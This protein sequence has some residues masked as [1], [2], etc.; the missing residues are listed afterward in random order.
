MDLDALDNYNMSPLSLAV[1]EGKEAISSA[2]ISWDCNMHIKDKLGNSLLH[3]A[4]LSENTS[5]SKILVL[6]GI[7]RS[8]K[9]LDGLT[10]Y[11]LTSKTNTK[12]LKIV[13]NPSCL[14]SFNPF[15]PPLSPT[16][17]S[18]ML[19]TLYVFIFITRYALVLAFLLPHLSIELSIGSISFFIVNFFLFFAV[20]QKDPGYLSRSRGQNTVKLINESHP[21]NICTY[22]EIL[23]TMTVFHCHHCD[24]CVEGYDHHCPW[25]R[26]CVG[27]KNYSTF[28]FFLTASWMDYLYT[29]VLGLLDFFQLLQKKRR[30]F[31]YKTYHKELGL[32]VTV[33]CMICFAFTFPIWLAQ[34]KGLMRKRKNWV[35]KSSK[36][37]KKL[38]DLDLNE[39]LRN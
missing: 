18:Y 27:Q 13:Q 9:N 34:I 2:L 29:S 14:S 5:I 33:I 24:K 15:R 31:D 1:K 36:S 32:F 20:H 4:A 23:K 6:R 17:N 11:D 22:C 12:L 21:D 38:K 26:N 35:K 37:E 28:F 39:S 16:K 7:D 25:I 3:I 8:I 10:A 30:F 19:F